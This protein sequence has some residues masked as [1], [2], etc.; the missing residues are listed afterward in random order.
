MAINKSITSKLA[1]VAVSS[2]L[3]LTAISPASAAGQTDYGVWSEPVKDDATGAY[4][5]TVTFVGSSMVGATYTTTFTA[6][7]DGNDVSV[8]DASEEWISEETPFGKVF[9][10]NGSSE[11]NNYL[12]TGPFE[13]ATTVI[14]F[15][16]A[17]PAGSLGVV[18][19]DFDVDSAVVSATNEAG[20][21]LTGTE[22]VGTSTSNGFNLCDVT[23]NVPTVCEDSEDKKDVPVFTKGETSVT[24]VN[25]E[26][27]EDIGVNGWLQPSVAVKTLTVVHTGG[28]TVRIGLAGP[29]IPTVDKETPTLADTGEF[30]SDIASY[31]AAMIALGVILVIAARRRRFN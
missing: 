24:F 7:T 29:V 12:K 1:L 5:G 30:K 17:I 14:T 19:G 31:A 6:G 26:V 28:G 4:T 8:Q 11:T 15:T 3:A 9:G 18:L 13:S 27:G 20:T 23:I 10:A 25:S 2:V 22:L 21:A 16:T